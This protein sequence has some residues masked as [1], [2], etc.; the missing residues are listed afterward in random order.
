MERI[1]IDG[2]FHRVKRGT[3]KTSEQFVTIGGKA[4]IASTWNVALWLLLRCRGEAVDV[5]EMHAA[6][7]RVAEYGE[8]Q[9][10]GPE[11]STLPPDQALAWMQKLCPA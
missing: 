2:L 9:S 11:L 3:E 4:C 7:K 8:G 5:A 10:P 1:D 6:C